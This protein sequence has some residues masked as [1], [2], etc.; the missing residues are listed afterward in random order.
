MNTPMEN[1]KDI[2]WRKSPT[3]M[4]ARAVPRME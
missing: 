1:G 4:N 2:P 3:I